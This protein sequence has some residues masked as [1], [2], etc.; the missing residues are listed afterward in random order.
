MGVCMRMKHRW[1]GG[2]LL[3]TALALGAC[4]PTDA[5]AD[6]ASASPTTEATDEPTAAPESAAPTP[7]EGGVDEY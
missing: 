7:T 2:L 6:D 5:G 1:T 3:A 4:A